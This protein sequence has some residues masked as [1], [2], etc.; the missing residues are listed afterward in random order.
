MRMIFVESRL[1][2]DFLDR[3]GIAFHADTEHLGPFAP[4]NRQHTVG[5][6][7]AERLAVLEEVFVR[8]GFF[9]FDAVDSH[10]GERPLFF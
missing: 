2:G 4:V 1:G 7:L 9:V 3:V 8:Q 5:G 6:N 10:R